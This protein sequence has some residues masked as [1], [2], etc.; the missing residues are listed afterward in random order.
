LLDLPAELAT[1]IGNRI[2]GVPAGTRP[3]TT[4][5]WRTTNPD[6]LDHFRRGNRFL[7]GRTQLDSAFNEYQDAARL[8]PR[9]AS[10]VARSAYTLA[11]QRNAGAP[12]S[13]VVRGLELAG[14][15]L[16]LDSANSDAWM[17]LGYLRAFANLKTLEGATAAFE[18]AIALD[19]LN[20]EAWHQYGQILSW[21]GDDAA[22]IRAVE[23]ALAIEPARA[24][25]LN[26]M[27]YYSTRTPDRAALLADSAL[28]IAPA[29]IPQSLILRMGSRLALRQPDAVLASAD[30]FDVRFGSSPATASF[31]TAAYAMRGDSVRA[32]AMARDFLPPRTDGDISGALAMLALG[33]TAWALQ[34]L[35]HIPSAER[36]AGLWSYLRLPAFDA[37]RTNPRFM[38]VYRDARPPGAR[39]P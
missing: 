21:L 34:H 36:D 28:A 32:R 22:A 1:E 35:E 24:V 9:F 31:R 30:D 5:V 10:A 11:L 39:S 38:A 12:Q 2:G 37:L 19:S 20:A 26:D 18:R 3:A 6:A 4:T 8:D 23:R 27:G 13:T 29:P 16:G 15:A 14:A 17:A 25:S 33:D 7:A